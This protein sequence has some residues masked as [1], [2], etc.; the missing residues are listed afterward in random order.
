MLL[1]GISGWA[2]FPAQQ[3]RLI[4]IVGVLSAPVALSLN[5]SFMYLGFSLGA[6][7]GSFSL[8]HI[9]ARHL[10]FVGA[11]CELVALTLLLVSQAI[12]MRSLSERTSRASKARVEHGNGVRIPPCFGG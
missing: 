9:D 12:D 4:E 10:G 6:L 5:A 8:V 11:A 2:F 1:W 7:L 3:A